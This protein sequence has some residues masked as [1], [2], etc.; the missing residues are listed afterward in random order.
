MGYLGSLMA[1]SHITEIKCKGMKQPVK[2]CPNTLATG[3]MVHS[4]PEDHFTN[5][6]HR[7]LG[8]FLVL[9]PFRFGYTDYDLGKRIKNGSD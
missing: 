9:H 2:L 7:W 8:F 3:I 6:Q 4:L 5:G 1:T